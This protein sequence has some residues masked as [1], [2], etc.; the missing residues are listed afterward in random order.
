MRSRPP[1]GRGSCSRS[2]TSRSGPG[3]RRASASRKRSIRAARA[4]ARFGGMQVRACAQRDK[5]HA[6]NAAAIMAALHPER[7]R[8]MSYH[9][10]LRNL[11]SRR[12]LFEDLVTQLHEEAQVRE[13]DLARLARDLAAREARVRE[14]DAELAQRTAL[15]AG[16]GQEVTSLGATVAERDTQLRDGRR[17]VQG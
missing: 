17:E 15:N 13:S 9:E 1:S 11:E 2:S 10:A 3:R 7:A 6:A 8:A 16:L 14:Q 12:L 4:P 5:G